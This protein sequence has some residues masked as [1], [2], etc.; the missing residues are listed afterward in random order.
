MGMAGEARPDPGGVTGA[1]RWD[2]PGAFRGAEG[3]WELVY[4]PASNTILHFNFR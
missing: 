2:V 3:T 4:D 1:L